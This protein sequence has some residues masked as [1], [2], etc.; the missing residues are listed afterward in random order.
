MV[1]GY[2]CAYLHVSP[3][4]SCPVLPPTPRPCSLSFI[5]LST[6]LTF[7]SLGGFVLTACPLTDYRFWLGFLALGGILATL[8]GTRVTIL[9]TGRPPWLFC[10]APSEM[11]PEPAPTDGRPDWK[12][13]C[14][15]KLKKWFLKALR[16]QPSAAVQQTPDGGEAGH[17]RHGDNIDNDRD[18]P[19]VQQQEDG[20]PHLPSVEHEESLEDNIPAIPTANVGALPTGQGSHRSSESG[21]HGS[22]GNMNDPRYEATVELE[23]RGSI[24]TDDTHR[25]PTMSVPI[26]GPEGGAPQPPALPPP[27]AP[28]EPTAIT[29]DGRRGEGTEEVTDAD[30]GPTSPP[31]PKR[32]PGIPPLLEGTGS[33][34]TT[35]RIFGEVLAE[36][37]ADEEDE[38]EKEETPADAAQT[39]TLLANHP[40]TEPVAPG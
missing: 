3:F 39:P 32:P 10:F 33:G 23:E 31:R 12:P 7:T 20:N 19:P 29:E 5:T 24:Q 28:E 1:Y 30:P 16:K 4:P 25:E 8:H 17:V 9:A 15:C 21:P 40:P 37:E 6:I 36:D 2:V 13:C 26:G 14:F 22:P 11:I 34:P 38:E 18:I 35:G 27:E